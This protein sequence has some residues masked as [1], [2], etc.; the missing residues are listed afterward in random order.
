MKP[1]TIQ[2][3]I[4]FYIAPHMKISMGDIFQRI[5][6]NYVCG[7]NRFGCPMIDESEHY[8]FKKFFIKIK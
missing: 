4:D 3:I 7:E 2:A 5:G 1:Q 6:D 8:V